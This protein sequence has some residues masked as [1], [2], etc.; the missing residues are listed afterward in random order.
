LFF[1]FKNFQKIKIMAIM[2]RIIIIFKEIYGTVKALYALFFELNCN[3]GVVKLNCDVGVVKLNCDVGV[4]KL[5]CD[6][7][8][9]KSNRDEEVSTFNCDVEVVKLNRDEGVVVVVDLY[10]LESRKLGGIQSPMWNLI[11]VSSIFFKYFILAKIIN[12]NS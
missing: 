6:V 5:N 8:V 7:G 11:T 4:V 3:V 9:V 10:F 12:I 2:I 1:F